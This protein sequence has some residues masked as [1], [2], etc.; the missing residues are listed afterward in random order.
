MAGVAPAAARRWMRLP[1]GR[2]P[3]GPA[4]DPTGRM[5]R[6]G[7]PPPALPQPPS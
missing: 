2:R 7:R 6:R 1:G 5:P 4:R 3:A